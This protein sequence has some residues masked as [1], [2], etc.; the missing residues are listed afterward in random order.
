MYAK[1]RYGQNF[2]KSESIAKKIVDSL[3][4]KKDDIIIEIGPGL[5]ALT[6]YLYKYEGYIG[7]EID[8]DMV[9]ALK[10][11]FGDINIEN[12][13]FLQS[14]MVSY[15]FPKY[16]GNLPYYIVSKILFKVIKSGFENAVFMVQKEVAYRITSKP[17]N[18]SYG[19]LSA[20][21][22][23][24]C[25]VSFLF[26]VK[27]DKF[28][29]SPNVDSAVVKFERNSNDYD[30]NFITFLKRSFSMKRK[31][32]KNNLKKYYSIKNI[33][34]SF[35]LAGIPKNSRAEELNSQTLRRLYDAL[36]KR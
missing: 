15:A 21:S 30:Q 23:Y 13:D 25:D 8:K 29:P 1:K 35:M 20:F 28:Y 6:K 22:Q 19:F 33:E 27:R 34:A 32:L 9:L 36:D 4:L 18:R 26:E 5:G 2:L 12:I 16:V 24:Y 3:N 31:L 10:N 17:K 7:I 14:D 11:R